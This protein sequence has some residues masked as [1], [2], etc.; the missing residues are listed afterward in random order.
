MPAMRPSYL[1]HLAAH[2]LLV[3]KA[4]IAIQKRGHLE[5]SSDPAFAVTPVGPGVHNFLN[6][7]LRKRFFLNEET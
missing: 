3:M 5:I 6:A 1:P 2:G 4:Y 7:F